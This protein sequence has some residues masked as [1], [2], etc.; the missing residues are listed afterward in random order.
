LYCRS[1]L[2]FLELLC[3]FINH[4]RDQSHKMKNMTLKDLLDIAKHE[5]K[6][7]STLENPDFRLEQAEHKKREKIW[8]IVVSYLVENTNKRTSG[9]SVSTPDFQFHRI[10]KQIKIADNKS[11]IGFYIYD[12]NE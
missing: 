1:L 10:Y 8:V 5:L 4:V 12:Y 7:L 11:I 9:S 6:D 2:D 3:I